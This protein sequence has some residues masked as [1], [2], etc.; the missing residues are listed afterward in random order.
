[1]GTGIPLGSCYCLASGRLE[2]T[3][4]IGAKVVIEGPA[5]FAVDAPNGGFLQLGNMLVEVAPG[6]R[7]D[8]AERWETFFK[9]GGK[10]S[11]TRADLPDELADGPLSASGSP[12]DATHC[13]TIMSDRG[14]A[15]A[16]SRG[17]DG[18]LVGYILKSPVWVSNSEFEFSTPRFLQE[19]ASVLAG[20]DKN[21]ALAAGRGARQ[22]ARRVAPR[23]ARRQVDR[24]RPEPWAAGS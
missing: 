2:I 8:R 24:P 17:T 16:A 11:T 19:G 10:R 22:A 6:G 13:H 18:S 14:A 4:N 3:Y 12:R 20:V 5:M 7:A 15:F 21:G 1:M 9:A 23:A